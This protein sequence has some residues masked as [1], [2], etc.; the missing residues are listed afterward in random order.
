MVSIVS[1]LILGPGEPAISSIRA[2]AERHA[3]GSHRAAVAWAR[4]QGVIAFLDAV[5]PSISDVEVIVGLN[6]RGTSI[7]ALLRL[8]RQ[9]PAVY[10][11]F[12]HRSQTFHPKIFS[13]HGGAAGGK[14][15]LLVGSSNLTW[16]GLMTN[17]EASLALAFAPDES[18]ADKNL[19]SQSEALWKFLVDNEF[20]H[21]IADES[22]IES[23]Y[24]SGYIVPEKSMRQ[25]ERVAPRIEMPVSFLPSSPPPRFPRPAYEAV[26]I[27]FNLVAA[28]SG[29]PDIPEDQDPEAFASSGT[30]S[31]EMKA[32]ELLLT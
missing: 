25:R 29:V 26:N 20:S 22:Y 2:A 15:T 18:P 7:E 30:P 24:R 4:E 8:F 28:D 32:L 6:E 17:I 19:W 11:F 16:G 10:V 13:F 9:I 3:G 12:K 5:S 27:P 1:Q 21:R 23:L 14:A 31:Q